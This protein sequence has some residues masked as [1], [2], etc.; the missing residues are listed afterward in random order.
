MFSSISY[1]NDFVIDRNKLRK[2]YYIYDINHKQCKK[3][4][5]E[6]AEAN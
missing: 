1:N 3:K 6:T 5:K 4:P 2:Y